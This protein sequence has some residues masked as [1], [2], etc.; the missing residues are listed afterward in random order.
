MIKPPERDEFSLKLLL[1]EPHA[2][3]HATA[4]LTG[5][6]WPQGTRVRVVRPPGGFLPPRQPLQLQELAAR[7]ARAGLA[8]VDDAADARLAGSKRADRVTD[9]FIIGACGSGRLLRSAI[10]DVLA[11]G[12][13]PLL[14]AGRPRLERGLI[15]LDGDLAPPLADLLL[16]EPFRR[17]RIRVL[18]VVDVTIPWYAGIG[19]S[20]AEL[21]EAVTAAVDQAHERLETA[22]RRTALWMSWAGIAASAEVREGNAQRVIAQ[23]ALDM[24]ADW[25]VLSRAIDG[26]RSVV[27]LVDRLVREAGYSVLLAPV[28]PA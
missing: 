26:D 13:T 18:G 14:V 9:L 1:R 21:L 2:D 25:V 17:A 3:K 12:G 5:L 11:A 22:T 15:V 4:F 23:S 6:G 7:L 10:V 16:R 20:L 28:T 8:L 24:A 27:P 19:Y